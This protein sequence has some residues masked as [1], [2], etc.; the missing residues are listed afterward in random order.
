MHDVDID[1]LL[2]LVREA[3]QIALSHFGGSTATLKPDNS[4]VTEADLAVESAVRDALH[5]ARPG[6]AVLGEEGK[7]APPDASVVWAIDPIDGTRAFNHGFP[8]WGISVGMLIDGLP[9]VGA[10]YLPVLDDLYHTDGDRAYCNSMPLAPPS[11]PVEGNSVLLIS[12]GAFGVVPTGYPGKV[13]GFGSATAHLCYVAKGSAVGAV[14]R[15]S[16]WD[17]AAAAAILR[18]VDVPFRYLSGHDVD[19]VQLYDGGT[20][21]EPTLICSQPHFEVLQAA[22]IEGA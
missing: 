16:I 17:Y 15:A 1:W 10:F 18:A 13:L 6:E 20:A 21:P 3:G 11:P 12:E 9:T 19:F 22:F 4:W 14:D 8:V 7:D 5:K 2:T